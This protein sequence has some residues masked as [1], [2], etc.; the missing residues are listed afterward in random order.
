MTLHSAR[1]VVSKSLATLLALGAALC[2]ATMA[3]A[4]TAVCTGSLTTVGN[5]ANGINGLYV[6]VAGSNQIRVCSFTVT[7]FSVTPEDCK[8]MASIAALAFATDASVTFYVDNAPSTSCTS[9][10]AWHVANTRYF[11]LNR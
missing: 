8:H 5:H 4:D 10:P 11:A 7:Q 1:K 3:H 9:I 2:G 6:I